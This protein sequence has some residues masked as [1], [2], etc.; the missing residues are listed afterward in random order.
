MTFLG[1]PLKSEELPRMTSF[2]SEW[3]LVLSIDGNFRVL[4]DIFVRPGDLV[5]D[6]WGFQIGSLLFLL[7]GDFPTTGRLV[8]LRIF[9][10]VTSLSFSE[11][12][13]RSLG[14]LRYDGEGVRGRNV[15]LLLLLLVGMSLLKRS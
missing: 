15:I 10:M 11:R 9:S 6:F 7:I 8:V 13:W 3:P 1:D 5:G 2:V 12:G 4:I 14:L